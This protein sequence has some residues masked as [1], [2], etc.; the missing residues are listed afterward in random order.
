MAQQYEPLRRPV[1]EGIM[2]HGYDYIHTMALH[3]GRLGDRNIVVN[4]IYMNVPSKCQKILNELR[5]LAKHG[6]DNRHMLSIIDMIVPIQVQNGAVVFACEDNLRL[7]EY[8][9]I[10]PRSE[11]IGMEVH[12]AKNILDGMTF[13]LSRYRYRIN[14]RNV[15]VVN[16]ICCKILPSIECSIFDVVQEQ[17]QEQVYETPPEWVMDRHSHICESAIVYMYSMILYLLATSHLPYYEHIND[18]GLGMVQIL[19]RITNDHLRPVIPD[20]CGSRLRPIITR[21]FDAVTVSDRPTFRDLNMQLDALLPPH[22]IQFVD[23]E[24]TPI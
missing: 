17:E 24:I 13:L 5:L 23:L 12:F 1:I 20:D 18:Q 9:R 21:I 7:A 10:H 11:T 4:E 16:K 6:K 14:I 19:S 15:Y 8:M 2:Y 22:G 3:K